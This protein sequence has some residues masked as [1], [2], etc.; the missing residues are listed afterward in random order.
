M[1][2]IEDVNTELAKAELVKINDVP[3]GQVLRDVKQEIKTLERMQKIETTKITDEKEIEKYIVKYFRSM[4]INNLNLY[5][6]ERNSRQFINFEDLIVMNH[7]EYMNNTMISTRPVFSPIKKN[8]KCLKIISSNQNQVFDYKTMETALGSD[9][10]FNRVKNSIILQ[11]YHSAHIDIGY[12]PNRII[13]YFRNM[14]PEEIKNVGFHK[15]SHSSRKMKHFGKFPSIKHKRIQQIYG[16]IYIKEDDYVRMLVNIQSEAY[17][18]TSFDL[19]LPEKNKT[20]L[21]NYIKGKLIY[22]VCDEKYK[23]DKN[24]LVEKIRKMSLEELKEFELNITHNGGYYGNFDNYIKKIWNNR[25]HY[26]KL[27]DLPFSK[28]QI[29]KLINTMKA[30]EKYGPVSNAEIESEQGCVIC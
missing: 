23:T 1:S 3:Y 19:V 29:D 20:R 9:N 15:T 6:I 30:R 18:E 24:E 10:L 26:T 21:I 27:S 4:D 25:M 22:D 7:K 11:Y 8:I 28:I 14:T 13:Q 5:G 12:K 17:D 2:K 16:H